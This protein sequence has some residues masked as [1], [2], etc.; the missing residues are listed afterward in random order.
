MIGKLFSEGGANSTAV[1]VLSATLMV[2]AA[3]GD[4][5]LTLGRLRHGVLSN[6]VPRPKQ[7][8]N[9]AASPVSRSGIA[10]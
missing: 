2:L 9:V 4:G 6:P 1:V 7:Q 10:A 8:M 5:P 3:K